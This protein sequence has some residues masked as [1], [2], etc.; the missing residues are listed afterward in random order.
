MGAMA[1]LK[2]LEQ[3]NAIALTKFRAPRLKRDIVVRPALLEAL[4]EAI[5]SHPVTLVCAAGG[6]GKTILLAQLAAS[7]VRN[8]RVLWVTVEGDDDDPCRFFASLVRAVEPL[9]LSWEVAP[10]ALLESVA[11]SKAHMRAALAALVNALCTTQLPRVVLILDDLHR[12]DK[13]EVFELLDSLIE[14]LPD[15]VAVVLGSRVEPPLSL[16]RWRAY[17]E[18]ATFDAKALGFTEADA[19]ALSLAR[20]GRALD[21][22]VLNEA[23]KRSHGWAAGL[24]LLLDSRARHPE[25]ADQAYR[26]ESDRHLFNYLAQ[27]VLEELPEALQDFALR[28][29][30][31]LELNPILC[32]ALTGRGDAREVLESLYRRNLFLTAL[33]ELEPVLR[34]HDLFRE[35]L[36][37]E[38]TRRNPQL[39]RELHERAAAAEKI[40]SRAIYHLLKAERWG[41]AMERMLMVG[42][43]RLAHG[44]IAT[45]ERWIASLP[46]DARR[47]H[48]G[49][50]YLSGTCAWFRW[51]WPKAKRELTIAADRLTASEHNARRVRAIFH[52]AD[53]LNSTGERAAAMQRIEQAAALP[54]DPLGEAELALQRSWCIA[55]EGNPAAVARHM[56]DFV[57]QVERHPGIICRE[58]ADR[59]HCMLIGIPGVVDAFERF[60][61]AFERVRAESRAHWHISALL[62]GGWAHLWRGRRAQAISAVEQAQQLQHQFGAVRLV[63]ERLGQLQVLTNV[64]LRNFPLAVSV[65]RSHIEK[66]Q[67]TQMAAHSAMWLRPYRFGLARAYWAQGDGDAFRE[68]VPYLTV[69]PAPGEWPF[70]QMTVSIAAAQAAVLDGDWAQAER[71]FREALETHDRLRLPIIHADARIGL[72]HVLLEQGRKGEAWQAFEPAYTEVIGERAIGLLLLESPE[73]VDRLLD[74]VPTELRRTAEHAW[75][76][77]TWLAWNESSPSSVVPRRAGALAVLSDRECEVLREVA[78]GASNKHIARTLSLSL[79]TVKRHIANILDK[80]DCDSRGQAADIFR[81]ASRD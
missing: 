44:G 77:E 64:A 69:P 28:C 59:V 54:L 37:A 29:S 5:D 65:T 11:S 18:L 52:L 3:W 36:E 78:S 33:D 80:L 72:A 12:I 75:L 30:I 79:H 56:Q 1:D 48:A 47:R 55:P 16:A 2:L 27:E 31:L 57:A 76:I 50:A 46:E 63:R 35:F 13:P 19:V 23:L 25:G 8:F 43:E 49:I 20:F 51:D 10:R 71:H 53:A 4:A 17:G 58:T 61:A 6:A 45:V 32:A 40:D 22:N 38:L 26:I 70:V 34:F 7:N 9:E 68:L 21:R 67:T 60:H 41:E 66:M 14:R 73:I 24:S 62:V 42:E 74:I 39:K 81:R 15:H